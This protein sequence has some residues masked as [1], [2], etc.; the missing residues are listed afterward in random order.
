MPNSMERW[1]H[2]AE[3]FHCIPAL[4]GYRKLPEGFA[5][6]D[7]DQLRQRGPVSSAERSV[8]QFLLHVWNLRAVIDSQLGC[9]APA[10]LHRLVQR[11][12]HRRALSLFLG[13]IDELPG[14][15]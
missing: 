11:A 6:D 10:G 1:R 8:L 14:L 9:P 5:P 13:G 15:S 7:V 12:R 2:L 4:V 3:N